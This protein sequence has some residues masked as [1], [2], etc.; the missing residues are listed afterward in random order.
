MRCQPAA[1]K[2]AW[3]AVVVALVVAVLSYKRGQPADA[4]GTVPGTPALSPGV[5]ALALF[6]AVTLVTLVIAW[7]VGQ[8]VN[9]WAPRYLG[10]AVVPALV[11][12]AGGLARARAR[13][14]VAGLTVLALAGTS[15]PVLVDRTVTVDTSKSDVSYLVAELAP[16]LQPG[17]LVISPEVTDTPVIAADLGDKYDYAT[18]FGPAPNPMVVNWSDLTARLEHTN[19]ATNLGPLLSAL[20]VGAQVLVVNPTSWGG[21]ETPRTYAGPVEAEAIAATNA[22]LDDP[23]LQSVETL[24]VPRYSNPLY[25]MNAKLFVKIPPSSGSH[26]S[27]EG[28]I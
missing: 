17:A 14:W 1:R 25:P 13:S 7:L 5:S 9:S 21:G 24:G 10:V 4:M 20:P 12:L 2:A 22:V 23:Q 18:P 26:A 19:A 27:G 8:V 3:A 15:V 6:T 11:P 28:G 16:I